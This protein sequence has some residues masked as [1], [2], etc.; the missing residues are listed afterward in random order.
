[1]NEEN[2]PAEALDEEGLSTFTRQTQK[3]LLELDA[4][5]GSAPPIQRMRTQELVLRTVYAAL[6]AGRAEGY[7]KGHEDE[8]TKG[9]DNGHKQGVADGVDKQ[10]RSDW[11]D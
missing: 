5:M 11:L 3:M 10:R 6:A 1:M 9:Y 7:D 4:I 2:K 8:Y